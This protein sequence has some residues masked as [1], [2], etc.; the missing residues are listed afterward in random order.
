MTTTRCNQ[1]RDVADRGL[2]PIFATSPAVA[3]D[4]PLAKPPFPVTRTSFRSQSEFF[5]KK[6]VLEIRRS[7]RSYI[8]P[9]T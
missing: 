3:V 2:W 6:F 8:G 9:M 5:L 7:F 4:F 1:V